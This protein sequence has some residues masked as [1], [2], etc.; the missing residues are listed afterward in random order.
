MIPQ[1]ECIEW[2]RNHPNQA[3]LVLAIDPTSAVT[4]LTALLTS[5]ACSVRC[6]ACA[7]VLVSIRSS[8]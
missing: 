7:F 2:K 5:L 4:L 6:M 1:S 8:R 3:E